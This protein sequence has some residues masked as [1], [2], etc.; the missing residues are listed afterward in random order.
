MGI[1]G[2]RS[3][4][5]MPKSI[6]FGTNT[7]EELPKLVAKYGRRT[8]LVY[9]G[10]SFVFYWGLARGLWGRGPLLTTLRWRPRN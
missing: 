3:A 1:Y 2:S 9:G 5:L 8:A 6:V 10:A 7:I 4:L